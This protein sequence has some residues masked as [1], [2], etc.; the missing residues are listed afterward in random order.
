MAALQRAAAR[1]GC[2]VRALVR[3]PAFVE[4]I[5]GISRIVTD[6]GEVATLGDVECS[7]GW[8]AAR[9]LLSLALEDSRTPGARTLAGQL[10]AGRGDVAFAKAVHAYVSRIP[11]IRERGEIFQSGAV[12]IGRDAGDCDDHFRLAY[13]L[14]V[15]GG[16]RAALGIL[17]HG[18]SAP[19]EKQ[20]PAHAVALFFVDGRWTWAETTVAAC[21]GEP[22]NEATARLG[23]TTERSDI[24]REI[25]IMTEEHLPPVPEGFAARQSAAQVSLDAQ[26]LQRLGYLAPDA[27]ACQMV[28]PTFAVLRRAV[29]AFQLARGLSPDALLGPHTRTE[30]AR[31]LD[32]AGADELSYPW[33]GQALGKLVPARASAHVSDEVLRMLIA[34]NDRFVAQGAT[35]AAE[36]WAQ[37]FTFESGFNSH[38]Q[39]NAVNP[40]TG[41]R[42]G[43]AGINQ[44]GE[45]ERRA[46]GFGLGLQAWLTLSNENQ[47]PFVE[48]F[49][50]GAAR[51]FGGG[52][53]PAVFRNAGSA[54]VATFAPAHLSHSAEPDFPL[55]SK[56]KTPEAYAANRGLDRTGK[57]FISVDDMRLALDTVASRPLFVELRGRLRALGASPAVPPSRG[58]G[59]AIVASLLFVAAGGG[60]ALAR[61][62]GWL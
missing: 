45:A 21:F 25:R 23:L 12:T 10:R 30:I 52:K 36:D 15:A 22:P 28:D 42:Y 14:G 51:D 54:Y 40:K 37:I 29:L 38:Q 50:K 39:T 53:G 31:A 32:E 6:V 41:K 7:D 4:V 58:P 33:P 5:G 2:K 3:G 57:G 19:I 59:P 11:F 26:A 55:Y 47:F 18:D 1:S 44:M 24:A 8:G 60:Y 34:M 62:R 16:L 9:L 48:C 61:S 35:T 56:E 46:C 17:H 27:P 20:G 49:Y 13:A 43:N